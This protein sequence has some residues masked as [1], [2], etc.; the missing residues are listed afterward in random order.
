MAMAHAPQPG[1]NTMLVI[2]Q[3]N[4]SNATGFNLVARVT[5]EGWQALGR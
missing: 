2:H 5:A 3:L 4:L 1:S